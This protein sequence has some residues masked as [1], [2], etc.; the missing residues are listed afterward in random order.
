[1][2]LLIPKQSVK[3]IKINPQ[4]IFLNSSVRGKRHKVIKYHEPVDRKILIREKVPYL[5][6]KW[7]S[8]Y[9]V[10]PYIKEI[11]PEEPWQLT[12]LGTDDVYKEQEVENPIKSLDIILIDHVSG[13]GV[14]GDIL[15][16][17]EKLAFSTLIPCQKAVYATEQNMKFFKR[18]IEEK[19]PGGPSTALSPITAQKLQEKIFLLTMSNTQDWVIERKHIRLCLRRQN[20]VVPEDAIKLPEIKINGP[21][22]TYEGKDI[23]VY[24]TINNNEFECVPVRF[25]IHHLN[26]ELDTDWHNK[27]PRVALL[28]EQVEL[29]KSIPEP[30]VE[31]IIDILSRYK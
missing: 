26:T 20:V 19:Q 8:E 7:E 17:D 24:I 4:S 1:M 30:P 27:R 10:G 13:I 14:K 12:R 29:N 6:S 15:K 22:V 11:K 18:I 16:V 9:I 21:N 2:S 5:G 23:I 3:L 25:M 28:E 31:E